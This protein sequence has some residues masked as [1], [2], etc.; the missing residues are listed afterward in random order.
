MPAQPF[1]GGPG[2]WTIAATTGDVSLE[3]APGAR[4]HDHY[5][6][7]ISGSAVPVSLEEDATISVE[8]PHAGA[9]AVAQAGVAAALNLELD[10]VASRAVG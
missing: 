2:T 9:P 7:Q 6:L 10:G 3:S 5:L 8:R 1:A 4:D